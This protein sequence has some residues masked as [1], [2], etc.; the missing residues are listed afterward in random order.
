MKLSHETCLVRG[1]GERKGPRIESSRST[2]KQGAVRREWIDRRGETIESR[3]RSH[4]GSISLNNDKL[5]KT[6]NE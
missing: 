2:R 5:I 3:H 1:C 6:S 4:E